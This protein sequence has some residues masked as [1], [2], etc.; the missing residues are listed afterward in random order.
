MLEQP[1]LFANPFVRT[2]KQGD[3]IWRYIVVIALSQYPLKAVRGD[4]VFPDR[5]L[6]STYLT[7]SVVDLVD[8]V[9]FDIEVVQPAEAVILA[10]GYQ[11]RHLVYKQLR[12]SNRNCF[13][14][15]IS[16]STFSSHMPDME[17][18]E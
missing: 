5:H 1:T 9:R 12:I 13:Q 8:A 4:D 3:T 14:Q 2:H 15:V 7:P 10:T 17:T 6:H 18:E 16:L 11:V